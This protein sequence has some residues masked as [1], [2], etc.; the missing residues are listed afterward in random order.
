MLLEKNWQLLIENAPVAIAISRDFKY[1]FCNRQY[2]KM[3]GFNSPEEL[4][5]KP[6]SFLVDKEYEKIFAKNAKDRENGLSVSDSYEIK[7]RK[8]D[9]SIFYVKTSVSL[10][11]MPKGKATMAVFTDITDWKYAH[12][13]LE[14]NTNLQTALAKITAKLV[15]VENLDELFD[16]VGNAINNQIPGNIVL[17]CDYNF[18]RDFLKIKRI[19][20]LS[21]KLKN[22]SKILGQDPMDVEFHIKDIKEEELHKYKSKKLEEIPEGLFPLTGRRIAKTI[23]KALEN[24]LGIKKV[25]VMG[26]TW[27]DKLYGGVVILQKEKNLN[28]ISFIETIIN[29]SSIA[30]KR[31]I[32]ESRLVDSENLYRNLIETSPDPITL[33]EFDGKII[34]INKAC[35]SFFGYKNQS[36]MLES[37]SNLQH[38]V[39]PEEG[40]TVIEN[41]NKRALNINFPI[42]EYT[43]ITKDK[44]IRNIEVNSSVIYKNNKPYLVLGILRDITERKQIEERYVRFINATEDFVFLKNEKFQY[45]LINE[46]NAAF[47]GKP[48]EEIIGKTDFDLMPSEI[49]EKCRQS[50]IKAI[51]YNTLIIEEEIIDNKVFEV[52]KFPVPLTNG[53]VGVG[54]YI[55]EITANKAFQEAIDK[56]LGYINFLANSA[57]NFIAS[58]ETEDFYKIIGQKLYEL[59]PEA[60]IVV[61]SVCSSNKTLTTEALY[62]TNT[63]I[64]KVTS[65]LGYSPIGKTIKYTDDFLEL[66]EGKVTIFTKGIHELSFKQ[67]PKP[68]AK[69]IEKLL[70]IDKIYGVAV[71]SDGNIVANA[72]MFFEKNYDITNIST[73]EA[74]CNQASIAY[75][76]KNAEEELRKSEMKYR[77][78]F[79][80]L[81]DVFYETALD[82]T[83]LEVSPSIEIISKGLYK[84]EDLLNTNINKY[85]ANPTVRNLLI[86]ELKKHGKVTDFEIDLKNKDG[87]IIICSISTR[88]ICDSNNKPISISGSMREIT[89]RKKAENALQESQKLY[90]IITEKITD[91]IWLMDL[92]GR[93][94]FVS[95]SIKRFTGF[96][97]EEYLS[98]TIQERFAKESVEYGMGIF[99][100]E[101][102][103]YRDKP[104]E[105]IDYSIHLELEY[106]CKNGGTKWGE[107]I[108]S[109]YFVDG[110]LQGIHG[111]TR[112]ITDRKKAESE[113]NKKNEEIAIQNEQLREINSELLIAKEK[114]EQADQLKTAFLANMSHEIRTPMNGIMGFIDLL[115]EPDIQENKQQ[116]YLRMV[117]QSSERLLTT[118]NDIIEISKIE[119]GQNPIKLSNVNID[120]TLTYFQSFFSC[121]IEE[122]C[123]SFFL[124][125]KFT[126]KPFIVKTDKA[127]LESILTNLLKNAIKFTEMGYICFGGEYKDNKLH[128]FVKDTGAGIEKS[129]LN[130]IFERFVQADQKLSRPYE[131]SGLGLSISK[132]YA[133]M[134]GGTIQVES[135]VGQGSI[136]SFTIDFIEAEPEIQKEKK[137]ISYNPVDTERNILVV[138]DDEV[139]FL[140]TEALLKQLRYKIIRAI[141]GNEAIELANS[142]EI[143][144]IIMDI[145]IPGIDGF[146]ATK[147]IR[148]TN[149]EIPIIAQTAYA[150]PEDETKALEAGCNY[151]L[152]KPVRKEKIREILSKFVL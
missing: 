2:L 128:F 15:G 67:I 117:K 111:V 32:T 3:T 143:D 9:G 93:S 136:F 23:C 86:E 147:T 68:L 51:E 123:L 74:F 19:F 135:T 105:L 52:R 141:S 20:G 73:I 24:F 50:D 140:Y 114:A 54:S 31:N 71:V 146:E 119:A 62:G 36:E 61:N 83:I 38:L 85:Y 108:I 17:V 30:I 91:V 72:V 66:A 95:P 142:E 56:H 103:R 60:Y 10:L 77:S 21:E 27:N 43:A 130:L 138:E 120:E 118:I 151:Y 110:Q 79:D 18:D 13:K 59:V 113:V 152:S 125:N 106:I 150:M 44:E 28:N 90:K 48:V 97:P 137:N 37:L 6:I 131:G 89:D 81:Q 98:Q 57:M 5:G 26:F 101:L 148:K 47:I 82:G 144:L 88:L 121:E 45:S 34:A 35:S 1:V 100:R 49:A 42:Q 16:L 12:E 139:S 99:G 53:K 94:L 41:L 84:R 22:I 96:T 127:K 126:P 55:R 122:K 129:K 116:Q 149:P 145:K 4:I 69:T 58:E 80:S 25:H 75:K 63:R 14:E 7:C 78:L 46:Q 40:K 132:A 104:E 11:D 107:L 70:N 65:F 29:Q 109:P 134:L 39:M 102:Q 124:E 92:N 133:E 64:S 8:K 115:L 112:D 76:R 33:S 87:S